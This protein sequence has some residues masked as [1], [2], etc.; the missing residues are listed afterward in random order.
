MKSVYVGRENVFI[1]TGPEIMLAARMI[2]ILILTKIIHLA[3]KP[4]SDIHL[5]F[6]PKIQLQPSLKVPVLTADINSILTLQATLASESMMRILL[7]LRIPPAEL[8]L[9]LTVNGIIWSELKT[10]HPRFH[11]M[12]T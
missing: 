6:L 3:S 9:W 11:Y 7:F 4:G 10:A 12:L 2:R 5:P 1:L 8:L